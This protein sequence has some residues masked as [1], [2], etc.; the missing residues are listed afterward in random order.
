MFQGTAW[1]RRHLPTLI[2]GAIKMLRRAASSRCA[3]KINRAAR[4]FLPF[5]HAVQ[6]K[7]GAR[8]ENRFKLTQANALSRHVR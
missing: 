4:N 8:E 1:R 6:H 7:S 5:C 2:K 3:T